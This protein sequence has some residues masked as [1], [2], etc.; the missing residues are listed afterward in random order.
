MME[1]ILTRYLLVKLK[2]EQFRSTPKMILELMFSLTISKRYYVYASLM[3]NMDIKE[4]LCMLY[5]RRGQIDSRHKIRLIAASVTQCG[6]VRWRAKRSILL[7]LIVPSRLLAGDLRTQT[8]GVRNAQVNFFIISTRTPNDF[9]INVKPFPL[10]QGYFDEGSDL[11]TDFDARVK[12]FWLPHQLIYPTIVDK[13][14]IVCIDDE[15]IPVDCR[16]LSS[17]SEYFSRYFSS[18]LKEGQEGKYPISDCSMLAFAELLSV[19]HPY[20]KP[21]DSDNVAMLLELARNGKCE[22]FLVE[23]MNRKEAIIENFELADKFGLQFVTE[24]LLATFGD[25]ANFREVLRDE[26][27]EAL[28]EQL[29]YRIRMKSVHRGRHTEQSRRKKKIIY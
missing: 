23:R 12:T 2:I 13:K 9:R 10:F 8:N 17:C 16:I 14:A 6:T 27:F 21:I 20:A 22:C 11:Y 28:P 26:K 4:L 15:E 7:W 3:T 18:S 1:R 24:L 5:I 29:K 19:V 25:G